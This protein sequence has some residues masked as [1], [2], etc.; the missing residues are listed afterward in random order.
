MVVDVDMV[1]SVDLEVIIMDEAIS[2]WLGDPKMALVVP[3]F[4]ETVPLTPCVTHAECLARI[5]ATY[6]DI[7]KCVDERRCQMFYAVYSNTSHSSTDHPRWLS[8][9]FTQ[10]TFPLLCFHSIRYE[11]YVVLPRLPSTP[12]YNERFV[13]YGKNKIQHI[14]HLRFVGFNFR[15][16]AKGFL[17][18]QAHQMSTAKVSWLTTDSGLNKRMTQLFQEFKLSLERKYLA[19]HIPLCINKVRVPKEEGDEPIFV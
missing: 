9:S 8:P 11:P 7:T 16:V 4:E 3:V 17:F 1:P 18:H 12:L 5:P 14:T 13:G 6:E 19:P 15:V 10:K 2:K